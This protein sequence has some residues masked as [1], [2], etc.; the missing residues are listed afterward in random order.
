MISVKKR[1]SSSCTQ[2]KLV[3]VPGLLLWLAPCEVRGQFADNAQFDFTGG[4]A[5]IP[6]RKRNQPVRP[7][8]PSGIPLPDPSLTG[9]EAGTG[10]P[11]AV[12]PPVIPGSAEENVDQST[13]AMAPLPPARILEDV[14]PSW[15]RFELGLMSLYD[16]NIFLQPSNKE[17][18]W[19]NRLQPRITAS[20]GDAAGTDW[21]GVARYTPNWTTYASNSELNRFDQG[22]ALEG[23]FRQPLLSVTGGLAYQESTGND[24]FTRD[25]FTNTSTRAYTSAD[26]VLGPSTFLEGSMAWS[27]AEL[28]N[29]LQNPGISYND[30]DTI[31]VRAAAL[32]QLSAATR[33]GPA[34]RY[35]RIDSSINVDRDIVHAL[36]AINYSPESVISLRGDLGAQRVSLASGTASWAPSATLGG[37]WEVDSLWKLGMSAY[38]RSVPSPTGASGTQQ[39]SGLTANISWVPDELLLV[40]AGLG[41]DLSQFEYQ[42]GGNPDRNDDHFFGNLSLRV[43]PS[44]AALGIQFFYRYRLTNSSVGNLDFS[45]SQGGVQL[46]YQ[47]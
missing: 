4:S 15:M 19:V 25:L 35:E 28:G 12:V 26:Y 20:I 7:L 3:A 22:G 10:P 14:V 47:F 2:R 11:A 13:A 5:E 1:G 6:V 39:S 23:T 41:Y 27:R 17:A 37:T 33:I 34:V 29:S 44:N 40:T 32:W 21:Y 9:A 16:S 31:D 30:Q 46:N 24:R 45:N 43:T 38:A 36:I 42:D 18:D 8:P